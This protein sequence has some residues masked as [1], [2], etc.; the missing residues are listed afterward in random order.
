MISC[1]LMGGLGNQLFQIFATISF[2]IANNQS[3]IFLY[4]DI[5]GE[6]SNTPRPTYWNNFLI[7]LKTFTRPMKPQMKV[8]RE[9]GFQYQIIPPPNE[10][11]DVTLLGYFQSH[12]YFEKYWS[13]LTRLIKLDEQKSLIKN[14]YNKDYDNLI[15]MHFRYGDY[16]HKQIFHPL[17]GYE[18]YRNSI[19]CI[20]EKTGNNRL[21]ILYFCEE[22]D[23]C[24]IKPIIDRL[25]TNFCET[26]F[27]KTGDEAA[28]WEQLLMMSLCSHNIIGNSSFSWWGAYFNS[29]DNKIVCYPNIWFGPAMNGT[30]VQDLFPE[31]WNKIS[32]K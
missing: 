7:P 3:F 13:T 2:A 30:N 22:E 20:I 19:Q 18:Y 11:E 6:G 24:I 10:N 27:I 8:F 16:K 21:N 25:E 26:T 9:N 5:L 31:S 32:A 12:K 15:S 17:M 29:H 1:E 14:K 23:E 4:K 28:D